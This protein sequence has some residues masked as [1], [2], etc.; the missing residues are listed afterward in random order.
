MNNSL[1]L[2][3]SNNIIDNLLEYCLRKAGVGGLNLPVAMNI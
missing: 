3:F 2:V 1:Y